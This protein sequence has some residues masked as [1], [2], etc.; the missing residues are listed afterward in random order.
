MDDSA[1]VE[2]FWKRD[3]Q[4]IAATTEKY[5]VYCLHCLTRAHSPL[6]CA[7]DKYKSNFPLNRNVFVGCADL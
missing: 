6:S 7:M 2:L 1:I 4:A 5:N 3:E